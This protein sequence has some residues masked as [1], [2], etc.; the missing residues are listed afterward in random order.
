MAKPR[1]RNSTDLD[2]RKLLRACVQG[3]A[4]GIA[5]LGLSARRAVAEDAMLRALTQHNQGGY[6]DPGFASV[7]RDADA[8]PVPADAFAGN[9]PGDRGRDRAI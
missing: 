7:A 3:A 8:R 1:N 4:A 9:R 6:F 2:R 5:G